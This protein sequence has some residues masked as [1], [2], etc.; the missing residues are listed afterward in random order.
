[1]ST[2]TKSTIVTSAVTATGTQKRTVADQIREI[3]PKASVM[4]ALVAPGAV[5]GSGENGQAAS[6]G[7][8]AKRKTQTM[9]FEAFTFTPIGVSVAVA[10]GTDLGPTVTDASGM[11]VGMTVMNM[12]NQTVGIIDAISTNAL[13]IVSLGT[14]FTCVA[15]DRLLFLAPAYKEASTNPAVL[16]KDE[17][18]IYNYVQIVREA[19]EIAKTAQNAPHYGSEP[20]WTRTKRRSFEN[21]KRKIE[22]TLLF[23]QR[24]TSEVTATANLGS[25][26]STRGATKWAANTFDANGAMTPEKFRKDFALAMPDT[27]DPDQDLIMFCGRHIFGDMNEWAQGKLELQT[28]GMYDKIGLKTFKFMTAGPTIQVIQ[29]NAFDQV[30]NQQK[31]FVFNPDEMAYYF[32]DGHDM[33][34]KEGIQANDADSQKDEL[35]GTCGFLDTTGGANSMMISNWGA[36]GAI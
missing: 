2:I 1:M 24:A 25:V 20:I 4:Q 30:G 18:N 34:I 8:I 27:V 36:S 26:Y 16:S 11:T 9:K 17:D 28:P 13:T 22:N 29:H 14:A 15:G 6:A 23:G 10:S 21:A 5:R 31:S 3:Y 35:I 7:R 33:A 12:S 32:L 19:V